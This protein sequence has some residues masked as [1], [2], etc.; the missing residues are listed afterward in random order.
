MALLPLHNLGI[1]WRVNVDLQIAIYGGL[2]LN[3]VIIPSTNPKA[4][5]TNLVYTV[6]TATLAVINVFL[7]QT[8]FLCFPGNPG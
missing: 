2:N 3:T 8:L 5:T 1:L 7:L 4:I 6:P